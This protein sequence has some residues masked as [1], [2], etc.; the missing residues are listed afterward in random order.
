MVTAVNPGGYEWT[1]EDAVVRLVRARMMVAAVQVRAEVAVVECGV[2]PQI[3]EAEFEQANQEAAAA[4]AMLREVI[5]DARA[6][7]I[8]EA[9]AGLDAALMG[10]DA[11][12]AA[13]V[14]VPRDVV[15]RAVAR[16]KARVVLQ[17]G[18]RLE[19]WA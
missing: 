17:L 2:L 8:G 13:G 11:P 10:T 12:T 6:R 19:G 7:V 5:E 3:V 16:E 14:V 15:A 1:L 4:S 9:A 18:R